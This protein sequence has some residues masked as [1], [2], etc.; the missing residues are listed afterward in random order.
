MAGEVADG[1][2]RAALS[3]GGPGGFALAGPFRSYRLAGV[4]AAEA[5]R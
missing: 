5:W 3:F 4:H 2:A 1:V